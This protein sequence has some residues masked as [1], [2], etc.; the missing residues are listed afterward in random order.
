MEQYE[1]FKFNHPGHPDWRTDYWIVDK[2]H[3]SYKKISQIS[4][5]L[6]E[7]NFGTHIT[8]L[9]TAVMNTSG[10]VFE[11]GCG[12]YST[13]QLHA[14]CETQKRQLLSTDTSKEW[15]RYFLDM[16]SQYH[17]F[18]HVPVYDDDWEVNP[19]PDQWDLVGNQNWGVVFVDHRPGDRRRVDV[20]RFADKA[21]IIVVHDTET[22]GYEYEPV[23]AKFK[24]RYNYKR[25]RTYTTLVSNTVDVRE[26][27]EPKSRE[28]LSVIIPQSI[29]E[30]GKKKVLSFCLWGEEPR[31]NV[32]A[33]KNA[34]LAASYY[35]EFECRYYIHFPSTPAST[36]NALQRM[37]NTKLVL[38]MDENI[39]PNRFMA[40]RF[41]PHD[42]PE[43]ELFMSRD[44]DTR[45]LRR[46]VL[47]SRE[48]LESGDLVHIMRDSP[49]HYPTILGGMFGLR[50]IPGFNMRKETSKYFDL[51]NDK[52]DQEFLKVVVHPLV[53]DSAMIHDE[54]KRYEGDKCRPFPIPYDEDF[55]FVGEYVYED[56]SRDPYYMKVQKNYVV[57]NMST[58]TDVEDARKFE[59]KRCVVACDLNQNY[60]EFY[61]LV[62]ECWKKIVGIETTL[63]LVGNTIPEKLMRYKDDIILFPPVPYIHSAFQA[64]CVRIL[65]PAIMNCQEGIITS[66]MDLI[67]LSHNYYSDIA[68]RYTQNDFIVYRD[69][70]SEHDQYP[71]CFCAAYPSSW[72][73]IFGVRS[74]EDIHDRLA[75]WYTNDYTAGSPSSRSWAAD[76]LELYKAVNKWEGNVVRLRDENTGFNRLDR[77]D[78]EDVMKSK[79]LHRTWINQAL[80]TDFHLPR[81]YRNNAKN[82]H[83]LMGGIIKNF[84]WIIP[85]L[86]TAYIV[87]YTKLTD[88][89]EFMEKQLVE[90]RLSEHLKLEWVTQ[91]DR[92]NITKEDVLE[93]YTFNPQIMSRPLSM[94]EI[95]NHLAHGYI[96]EKIANSDRPALIL[97]DDIILKPNFV[98]N[99]NRCLMAAPD[100]WEIL[101]IGGDYIDG[102]GKYDENSKDVEGEIIMEVPDRIC[103]TVSC[104][105][106][107]PSVA[108]RIVDHRLFYRFSAPIDEN[109]VHILPEIQPRIYWAYPFIAHEGSKADLFS[110]SFQE[111]GF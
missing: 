5:E 20:E 77:L 4:R 56:E 35:P 1:H 26:L 85:E 49:C 11:M 66:D 106:M 50:K 63:I 10:P 108:K 78:M 7:P 79:E 82:I 100:D 14:I 51:L 36:I 15:I 74:V 111:R 55:H 83:Y 44:T 99:L 53:R 33:V 22:S 90:S 95:A 40:W 37:P 76:Q 105:V 48:W 72:G 21:E 93:H 34:E 69:C 86:D 59:L 102:S 16:K 104:Y 103:T 18:Q 45:I 17:S 12:D 13:P 96:I 57:N 92:E 64:Q 62:R 42:D 9:L 3:K 25:Y 87:H 41:E 24:F 71:I 2:P 61:P 75:S 101:T 89:K 39:K 68:S 38:R 43:V 32:G 98:E 52:D 60:W 70:I 8:P 91:F 88:R 23:L 110:T 73:D 28:I 6:G 94:G 109:L 47:A 54:I 65:Y 107:R 84:D 97:E 27:F 19:K 81:P 31:Y 80:R 46:E 58:R 67:P 29:A 30:N